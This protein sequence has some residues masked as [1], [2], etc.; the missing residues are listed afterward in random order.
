MVVYRAAVVGT[1]H[2]VCPKT[3][4]IPVFL[5]QAGNTY[6]KYFNEIHNDDITKTFFN[7]IHKYNN[8]MTAVKSDF[9]WISKAHNTDHL[10]S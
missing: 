8:K 9:F 5:R 4:N 3:S 7:E 10:L 6:H 2:S 1:D